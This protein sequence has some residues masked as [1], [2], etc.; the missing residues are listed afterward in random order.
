M[1]S[2]VSERD[3]RSDR[4]VL[5]ERVSGGGGGEAEGGEPKTEDQLLIGPSSI[6][7]TVW[8]YICT[9][10]LNLRERKVLSENEAENS[11]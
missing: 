4:E 3:P 6:V 8:I 9:K 10:S 2:C 1:L 7:T 5:G 11:H